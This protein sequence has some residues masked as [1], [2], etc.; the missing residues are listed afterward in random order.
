MADKMLFKCVIFMFLSLLV[1]T[2]IENGKEESIQFTEPELVSVVVLAE[3]PRPAAKMDIP[4]QTESETPP[5]ISHETQSLKTNEFY[6]Y[7]SF[8][9]DGV[10]YYPGEMTQE[11]QLHTF[12]MCQKYGLEYEIVL[13]LI[14]AESRWLKDSV[15]T[16]GC[17]GYGQISYRVHKETMKN[18]GLD[19]YNSLDNIEYTC[20]LLAGKM[21]VYSDYHMALMAY[22]NGNEGANQYFKKGIYESNYSRQIM[23]FRE[24]LLKERSKQ[25]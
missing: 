7:S 11:E 9:V 24:G 23:T 22:K 1:I 21:S 16:S 17:I 4:S 18:Q 5:E 20:F 19:V 3:E 15:S 2:S 10:K 14:G 6:Y 12:N 8:E 13:A 25:G